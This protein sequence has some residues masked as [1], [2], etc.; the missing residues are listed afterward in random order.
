VGT[1]I[2]NRLA[3]TGALEKNNFVEMPQTAGPSSKVTARGELCSQ[4]DPMVCQFLECII[5]A[6][7]GTAV[8]Q[9]S[10]HVA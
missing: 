8:A 6:M 3:I 7:A 1:V 5:R 9:D 2:R 10:Y 4:Q